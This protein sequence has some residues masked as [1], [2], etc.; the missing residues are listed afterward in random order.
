MTSEPPATRNPGSFEVWSW[1]AFVLAGAVLALFVYLGLR[2]GGRGPVLV[3]T[4]GPL[5]LGSACALLMIGG[6]LWSVLRRPVL[7]RGRTA[8]F[9]ALA[10][11]LW[12]CSLPIAYPSSHEGHPSRIA[13]RL[14]FEGTWRVRWGGTERLDNPFVLN[15]SRCFGYAF[16]RLDGPGPDPGHR[17]AILAPAAGRVLGV[18]PLVLEVAPDERLVLGGVEASVAIGAEVVAGA[19]VGVLEE[20]VL[21]L[22]LEDGRVPGSGE[23]IPL[24]FRDY[25]AD[26]RAV[27]RGG[28]RRGQSVGHLAVGR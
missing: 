12:L 24:Q 5:V 11:G 21:E 6:L 17:P 13:Y 23:G 15:P 19:A 14:P 2:P 10:A 26:G 9:G 28:P 22:H 4:F 18:D 8:A 20:G 16:E 3:Y 27:E 7:Q 25:L 1:G